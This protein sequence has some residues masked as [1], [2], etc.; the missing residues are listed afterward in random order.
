MTSVVTVNAPGRRS[1]FYR[2]IRR[3]PWRTA[4][5]I[6]A[7]LFFLLNVVA[8]VQAW[9]MTHFVTGGS[10]TDSPEKL[11]LLDKAA[12]LL[13]G[14]R[15]PRPVDRQTPA[16][17]GLPFVTRHVTS[18]D[19]TA[20]RTGDQSAG[21]PIKCAASCVVKPADSHLVYGFVRSDYSLCRWNS[22]PTA[23]E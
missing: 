19:H 22:P 16:D 6:A 5:A 1:R 20:D 17:M 9:S 2:A 10:K 21:S 11:T 3:H 15:V 7:L 12:I 23:A 14:I 13:T 4:M 18:A 8:F